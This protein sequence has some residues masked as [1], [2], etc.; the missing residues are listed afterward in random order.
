MLH[1]LFC[2]IMRAWCDATCGSFGITMVFVGSRPIVTVV[3][4]RGKMR[5]VKGPLTNLIAACPTCLFIIY[6]S[7]PSP[8]MLHGN[9]AINTYL[10]LNYS[11]SSRILQYA[12]RGQITITHTRAR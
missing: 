4:C 2:Q 8:E 1:E 10:I 3:C 6:V 7:H 11:A 9:H 12:C 5:P